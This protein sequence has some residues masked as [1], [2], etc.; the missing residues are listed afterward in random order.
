MP[1]KVQDYLDSAIFDLTESY[2]SLQE[3]FFRG[4][5]E[6]IAE[7]DEKE[8]TIEHFPSLIQAEEDTPPE[9]DFFGRDDRD[10]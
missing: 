4:A 5:N 2:D 3:H 9:F 8:D 1:S 7:S 6:E 10:L